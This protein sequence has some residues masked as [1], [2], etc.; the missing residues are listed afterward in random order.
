MKPRARHDKGRSY[1]DPTRQAVMINDAERLILKIELTIERE[2]K[3]S[4][5]GSGKGKRV[6]AVR[7][8]A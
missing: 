5:G 1:G 7:R 2:K 3:R 6:S 8:W 4:D